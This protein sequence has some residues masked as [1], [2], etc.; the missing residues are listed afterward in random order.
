MYLE[1]SK[2]HPFSAIRYYVNFFI[3]EDIFCD[4]LNNCVSER[5]WLDLRNKIEKVQKSIDKKKH[6]NL[7]PG[8]GVIGRRTAEIV[9]QYLRAEIRPHKM[10]IGEPEKRRLLFKLEKLTAKSPQKREEDIALLLHQP[11]VAGSSVIPEENTRQ[12]IDALNHDIRC[13]DLGP[14]YEIILICGRDVIL[15]DNI[16]ASLLD[17]P[18]PEVRSSTLQ[19]G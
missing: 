5:Q 14:I 13:I 15:V 18:F 10:N 17:V 9:A 19:L 3:D 4:Y 2:V 12:W 11:S 1:K 7:V 8:T 6:E 16:F